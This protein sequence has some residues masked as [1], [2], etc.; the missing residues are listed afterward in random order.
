MVGINHVALTVG[1]AD[2]AEQFYRDVFRV[3]V[4]GRTDG[5]VFLDMGDQFV[6]LSE[7]NPR[8]DG[9]AHFGLVVDDAAAV[10]RRLEELDVDRLDTPGLDFR[11]PWG[12]RVQVVEYAEVQFTKADHVLDGMGLDL[13]KTAGA[14]A[15]LAEKGLDR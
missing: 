2:E 5:A 10:E 4:R 11:D 1:D 8:T 15:E 14:R 7:G 6:A 3:A 12:N 9:H 13:E